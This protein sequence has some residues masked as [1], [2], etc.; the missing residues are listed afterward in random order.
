[1]YVH[2]KPIFTTG[3]FLSFIH[4]LTVFLHTPKKGKIQP[5][6]LYTSLLKPR[7]LI[8]VK[9]IFA[10]Q[11]VILNESCKKCITF[12]ELQLFTGDLIKIRIRHL[13]FYTVQIAATI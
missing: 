9:L 3:T 8:I 11:D 4:I 12:F 2:S 7:I 10:V 13:L 5:R 6:M 1:M